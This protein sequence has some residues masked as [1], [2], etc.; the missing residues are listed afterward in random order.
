M[1]ADVWDFF[2]PAEIDLT[3]KPACP[4]CHLELPLTGECGSC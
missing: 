1:S 4:T 3:P 2:D